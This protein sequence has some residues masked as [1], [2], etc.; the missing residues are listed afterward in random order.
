MYEEALKLQE[1]GFHI[2]PLSPGS[3][4]PR[5]GSKGWNDATNDLSQIKEWWEHCS[6]YNI[7]LMLEHHNLIVVDCDRHNETID[8]VENY[9][10]LAQMYEP[11]PPTYTEATP[12]NGLHF[13]FKIPENVS[14]Q[15][16]TGAFKSI[17]KTDEAGNGLSGIDIITLGVPI[18][19]STMHD[20]KKYR[21]LDDKKITEIAEAPKWL[22]NLL[23]KKDST[24]KLDYRPIAKTNTAKNLDLL[25]QGA[26]E[27][28]RN[29]HLTSLC[30]W[31]L[32]HGVDNETLVELICLANEHNSPPLQ[33]KEIQQIIKSMIKKDSRRKLNG[34]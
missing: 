21:V 26:G 34:V 16:E 13:F 22:I 9:K 19:P 5:K 8:G 20:G 33:D 31:L 24:I 18:A 23:Q 14:I 7:G 29:D 25:I 17:F 32:W 11:F 1:Q 4:I 12:G 6:T 15:Q 3:K 27:G 10:K 2:Y 30:G 28:S